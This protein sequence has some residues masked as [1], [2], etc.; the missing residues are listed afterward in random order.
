MMTNEQFLF[1]CE[2]QTML[3]EIYL[4]NQNKKLQDIR[5]KCRQYETNKRRKQGINPRFP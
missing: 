2:S 4:L 5:D 3:R 1:I